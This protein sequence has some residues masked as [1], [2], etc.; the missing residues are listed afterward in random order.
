MIISRVSRKTEIKLL[1]WG[2]RAEEFEDDL[3][4]QM[5]RESAAVAIFVVVLMKSYSMTRGSVC[6]WYLNED[7]P[8]I[9]NC[10][11]RFGDQLQKVQWISIGKQFT[12]VRSRVD[13]PIKTVAEL[14][15]MDPWE[16]EEG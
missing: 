16:T 2:E 10:F 11:E 6:G 8:E 1:L 5:G 15:Y 14:T 3:V 4:Q 12:P 13:L 9:N 7:L